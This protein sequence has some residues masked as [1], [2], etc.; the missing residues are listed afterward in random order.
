M[1]RV[2]LKILKA[3]FHPVV[4]LCQLWFIVAL[5]TG[6]F[7]PD[8]YYSPLAYMIVICMEA[9]AILG[10]LAYF[11][12]SSDGMSHS[13]RNL[14][15]EFQYF[16]PIIYGS[17][18]F[19]FIAITSI[20]RTQGIGIG[21]LFSFSGI[22]EIS[23]AMSVARYEDQ[24]Q[25]PL[26]ARLGQMF[27]FFSSA[28]SGLMKSL[29]PKK[30][31]KHEYF[32][33][34]IPSLMIALILTTRAAVLFN[35]IFWVSGNFCGSLLG[36]GRVNLKFFTK[37]VAIYGGGGALFIAFMFISL[38]FLRGGITD[39]S[40]LN[41]VLMH[42]RQW[43]VGSI[44]GFSLWV[45]SYDFRSTLTN[46]YLTFVGIFD[47]F[48]IQARKAGLYDQ[49]VNLG[50]GDSWGN[51]Y[52][53]FRGLIQDFSILGALVYMGGIG[54]FSA[55]AFGKCVNGRVVWAALLVAMYGFIVWTP[56]VS[57]F[58][59]TAHIGA[60]VGFAIYLK[61]FSRRRRVLRAGVQ[62]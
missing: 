51:I 17:V 46:G 33:S 6:L 10:A 18:F 53:A 57:F 24:F 25:L 59:Y 48:G 60:C 43:P 36:G 7:A 52:T 50:S 35:L 28:V 29:H 12:I 23:H 39:I 26:G 1:W 9:S 47:L 8:Y 11:L 41:E 22:L 31:R 3:P 55:L 13:A 15:Y 61:Y 5:C 16:R 62:G 56:I 19:G 4:I 27:I 30:Y 21:K 37:R 38:Q 2:A 14:P 34:I 49:Y 20:L 40:R 45:D 54:F 32:V 58:S 44:G 42:L